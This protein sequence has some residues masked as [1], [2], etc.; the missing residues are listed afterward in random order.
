MAATSMRLNVPWSHNSKG[1]QQMID[2]DEVLT[3]KVD[4][5][6]VLSEL[7]FTQDAALAGSI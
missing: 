2:R 6:G 1:L 7:I 4:R 3:G 5:F